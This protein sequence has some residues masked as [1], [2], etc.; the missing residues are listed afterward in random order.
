MKRKKKRQIVIA[1]S[2][3]KPIN[4]AEKHKR[5]EKSKTE[6]DS[7]KEDKKMGSDGQDKKYFFLSLNLL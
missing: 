3:K 6:E 7:K 2:R 1:K 4:K 5:D